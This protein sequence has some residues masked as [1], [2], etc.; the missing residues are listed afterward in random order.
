[1]RT[2]KGLRI[3][4]D[5]SLCALIPFQALRFFLLSKRCS[6]HEVIQL[7]RSKSRTKSV[8]ERQ[9]LE[10]LRKCRRIFDYLLVRR[11]RLRKPCLLRSYVLLNEALK[12]GISASICIGVLKDSDVLYGHS[13]IEVNGAPFMENPSLLKEYTLMTKE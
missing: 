13:W 4:K 8:G 3:P 5:I 11:L 2:Y 7:I 1:M 9:S 10:E 6:A 12:R